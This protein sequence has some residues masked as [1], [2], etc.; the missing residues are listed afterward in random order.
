VTCLSSGRR[1]PFT[2]EGRRTIISGLGERPADPV[3]PVLRIEL[4]G[5]PA[6][7]LSTVLGGADIFPDLPR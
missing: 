7:D 2:Q 6:H 5:R 3:L 4:D 1:L